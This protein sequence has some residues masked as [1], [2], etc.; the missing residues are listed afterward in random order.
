[1]LEC[2]VVK[3]FLQVII[4]IILFCKLQNYFIHPILNICMG[5]FDVGR[6]LLEACT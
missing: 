6:C 5:K 2:V 3:F 4:C 1:M